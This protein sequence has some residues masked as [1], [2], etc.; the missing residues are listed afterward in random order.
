MILVG[1]VGFAGSGKGTFGDILVTQH[2]FVADSYA[3]PVKDAV[4]SIFGWDRKL[5][6]GDTQ[7]SREFRETPEK[8]WSKYFG[9]P[10]TPREALQ[11]MGTEC[12]RNVYH[13]N[14]WVD[15]LEQRIK[16]YPA[17][18]AIT[19]V[20]FPNEIDQ[21]VRLGGYVIRIKREPE[22]MWYN[23]AI[24]WNNVEWDETIPCQANR[25]VMTEF[26]GIHYSEFAWIGNP[27]ITYTIVNDGTFDDLSDEVN[28][29]LDIIIN[30]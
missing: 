30:L 29:L 2:G 1:I 28:K 27:K 4:A 7:E 26:P 10:F 17:N 23:Y 24:E 21:I 6:E 9:R 25:Q 18:Y 16:K 5:L 12:G 22:P 8:E 13:P 11:K 19:D 14:L 20:R 3:A 15:A